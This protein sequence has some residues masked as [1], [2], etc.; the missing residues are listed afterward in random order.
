M[1]RP[2]R[3]HALRDDEGSVLVT[4]ALALPVFLAMLVLVVDLANF[5][6]HKR[7]LQVQ[8]DAAVLAAVHE[9]HA[10]CT[11]G[12]VV[13]R[14][15]QYG[16]MAAYAGAGPYNTQVG[17]TNQ[18]QIH[19]RAQLA[20]LLRPELAGRRS[21]D[22]A[23]PCAARMVDMKLTETSLPLF[24]GLARFSNIN[25]Q[26]RAELRKLTQSPRTSSRCRSATRSGRRARSPSTTSRPR[27]RGTVLG[28]RSISANG[29]SGSGLSI[30]D[31]A[32]NPF[33]ITISQRRQEARREGR[34]QH[35]SST[36]CGATG[37]Q[38]LQPGALHA[39]LPG[40]ARGDDD[41][42]VRRPGAAGAHGH[43]HRQQLQR[44]IVHHDRDDHRRLVHR[45]AHR[46]RRLG[47]GQSGL[48]LRR[49]DD[50]EGQ[51]RH[52]RHAHRRLRRSAEPCGRARCRSRRAAARCR[53]RS[54]G[55]RP[56]A[57]SAAPPAG[58]ATARTRPVHRHLRHRSADLL[59]VHRGLRPDPG[60]RG[61]DGREPRDRRPADVLPPVRRRERRL[62]LPDHRAHRAAAVARRGPERRATRSTGC[63]RSTGTARRT[64]S[65]ATRRSAN[66]RT[67]WR[68]GCGS[69]ANS[70]PKAYTINSGAGLQR[71]QQPGRAA[72]PLAVRGD[73]DRPERQPDRQGP[74]PSA[75]TATRSP[76]RAQP[77]A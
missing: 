71:V 45:D 8:A 2:R 55:A 57:P 62:H 26:A 5:F 17:G 36:T 69:Q 31:N 68:Y 40:R 56:R 25:A 52:G 63:A 33:P 43:G 72:R 76:S 27:R 64:R 39:R 16:G 48:R 53:S 23:G 32:G 1:T 74:E 19:A 37:R 50:R 15:N 13:G 11:D 73:A 21:V 4:F 51:R 10:P 9:L 20:H 7:H 24:F 30:W 38:L 65:T 14:A 70:A 12:P 18:G 66:S 60:R 47:P 44:R 34:A 29:T 75:S 67:S 54:T 35:D 3:R 41:L 59:L 6:E 28:T 46:D 22:T 61:L 49:A 77:P 58:T 42:V